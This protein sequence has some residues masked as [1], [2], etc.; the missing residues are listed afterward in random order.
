VPG[1]ELALIRNRSFGFVF[2]SHHLMPE[3]TAL[4]NVMLP[5]RVQ[6]LGPSESKRRA[7]ELLLS[8]GLKDR[9]DHKPGEL[10]GGEQQ[11]VAVARALVNRPQVVFADE[12]TGN[13]DLHTAEGIH[14]ILWRTCQKEGRS[15]IVVTHYEPLA[16][17]A[18][19]VVTLE[20]GQATKRRS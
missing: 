11:R 16:K 5:C 14:D 12:P 1:S 13:L 18:D 6:R 15:L 2:Q 3:L 4:E 10:S 9:M 7:E 8:V 20:G 19:S 17:R